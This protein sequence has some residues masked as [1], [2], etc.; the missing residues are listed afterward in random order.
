M[1][2]LLACRDWCFLKSSGTVTGSS[3]AGDPASSGVLDGVRLADLLSS[4]PSG[5]REGA[6]DGGAQ[7]DCDSDGPVKA[8]KGSGIEPRFSSPDGR[9][10]D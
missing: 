8:K 1:R 6:G 10:E 7:I 9:R 5:V 4:V 3:G 2:I